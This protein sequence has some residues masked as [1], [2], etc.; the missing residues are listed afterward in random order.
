[1]KINTFAKVMKW[2]IL[3]RY[4]VANPHAL[5]ETRV[6]LSY[7][8]PASHLVFSLTFQQISRKTHA[9][10]FISKKNERT[11]IF[12]F[13]LP[14]LLLPA[15]Y[16][17]DALLPHCFKLSSCNKTVMDLNLRQSCAIC[18]TSDYIKKLEYHEYFL[19]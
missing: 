9:W 8:T 4:I 2:K 3:G 10:P 15:T 12:W 17:L 14:L 6:F 18:V 16:W 1:M 19:L 7:L 5:R 13:H 11:D